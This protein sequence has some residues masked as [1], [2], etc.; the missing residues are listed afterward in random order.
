M[1]VRAG[2]APGLSVDGSEKDLAG[3]I[4]KS[5]ENLFAQSE[6]LRY[7][8]YLTDNAHL[9]KPSVACAR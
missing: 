7:C 2:A 1:F 5:A 4:S 9:T 8:D 3:L 6:P